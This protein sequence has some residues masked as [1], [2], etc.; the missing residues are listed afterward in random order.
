MNEQIALV[1]LVGQFVQPLKLLPA[2]G[3]AMS[4]MRPPDATDAVQ[5]DPQL[6]ALFELVIDPL[7]APDFCVVTTNDV[8]NVAAA[9]E[10]ST[11]RCDERVTEHWRVAAVLSQPIQLEN[12]APIVSVA[13]ADSKTEVP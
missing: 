7:P 9:Y 5:V 6:M 2:F 12:A 13:G 1:V 4:V 11:P 10:A 3:A 8:G